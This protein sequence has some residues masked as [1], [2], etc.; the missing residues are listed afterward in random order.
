V[1]AGGAVTVT[2]VVTVEGGTSVQT[3]ST[4]ILVVWMWLAVDKPIRA[5]SMATLENFMMN[6][7]WLLL[8]IDRKFLD[9][10]VFLKWSKKS[11]RLW[12][13]V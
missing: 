13:S 9:Y 5:P 3:I 7:E 6:P 12:K 1:V 11:E 2:V 4:S 10:S 8:Q